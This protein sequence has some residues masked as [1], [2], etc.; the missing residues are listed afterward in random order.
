MTNLKRKSF[1]RRLS[2]ITAIALM[3]TSCASS[4]IATPTDNI[5]VKQGGKALQLSSAPFRSGDDIMLPVRD[6]AEKFGCTV[7]WSEPA[8]SAVI[9]NGVKEIA[10][11]TDNSANYTYNEETRTA[12]RAAQTVNDRLYF[13]ADAAATVFGTVP[14]YDKTTD[15]LYLDSA[16]DDSSKSGEITVKE[17]AFVE[18]GASAD[19][20]L[21]SDK[22]LTVKNGSGATYRVAY[23]KF[24]ISSI[25][26]D[27]NGVRLRMDIESLEKQNVAIAYNFYECDPSAWDEK[28]ITYNTQPTLGSL[29]ASETIETSKA[30]MTFDLSDYVNKSI[31][32]GKKEIAFAIS[33]CAY[34]VNFA[35]KENTSK[36]APALVVESA[37]GAYVEKNLPT[38]EGFGKNQDPW[39]WA[40]KMWDESKFEN[41]QNKP[42]QTAEIKADK[43]TFATAGTNMSKNFGGQDVIEAKKG[44]DTAST[45]RKAFVG[46]DLGDIGFDDISSATLSLMC[47][48]VQDNISHKVTVSET[49]TKWSPQTLTWS[50]MP[51]GGE[52]I[53]SAT[54]APKEAVKFDVSESIKSALA[55]GRTSVSYLIEDT[56]GLRTTFMSDSGAN[57]PTLTVRAKT[58]V[59]DAPI[60]IPNDN[61]DEYAITTDAKANNSVSAYTAFPTRVMEN[62]DGFAINA[63]ETKLDEYGGMADKTYE[64]TGYFRT[65]YT[66][67]RWWLIDPLGHPM[68]HA[69]VV[70]INPGGSENEIAGRTAKYGDE[71]QW[72]QKTTDILR[73]D[74]KFNGAGAWSKFNYLDEAEN[75][76]D[77]ARLVYFLKSYMASIGMSANGGGSTA[78]KNDAFNVFDPDFVDFCDSFAAENIAPYKEQ[79]HLVGWMSDNEL[80]GYKDMLDKALY[81]D[82]SDPI[83]AYSYATAWTFLRNYTGNENPSL[84]MLNDTMRDDYRD[85]IY[86]RY[87]NVVS[88]AVKKHDPN[89]MY[90]GCRFYIYHAASEGCWAAAGRYCDVVTTNYY[91]AWT[92]D[93]AQMTDWYSW[94]KRPFIATEWYAMGYDSGL[95]CSSGA[96]WR[97]KTQ[98]D[99]GIFYENFV[100]KLLETGSCVGFHWF[101]YLDNDPNATGR[102]SSNID[103]NKGIVNTQF[104]FYTQLTDR[105]RRVNRN[106]YPLIEYFENRK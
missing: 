12:N 86:D 96:G 49:D 93:T 88:A 7:I 73:N 29:I 8:N 105:M 10:V 97:T 57:P 41:R 87:F 28:A 90:L 64:A 5:I 21:G 35:S 9:M 106:M 74:L 104:E 31:A 33:G 1:F 25:P 62:L 47:T 83:N 75:P 6:I 43:S 30:L 17:D 45:A 46:F 23:L 68:I 19:N 66:D 27:N 13:T 101:Q 20:N 24:D 11:I 51:K 50:N 42:S 18:G 67:G 48:A 34:R 60:D 38:K 56:E 78:F 92:P 44:A 99:R 4:A 15:V 84:T 26:A 72:A 58:I 22:L 100:L 14:T 36:K 61:E 77:G 16:E 54:V 81:L 89:H 85:F 102:D 53:A 82:P 59:A 55:D 37:G 76:L 71:A 52:K 2:I 95:K 98:S 79:K 70:N 40:Q 94:S 39:E 32:D 63:K 69:A 3:M 65:E 91:S 103:G 80:P